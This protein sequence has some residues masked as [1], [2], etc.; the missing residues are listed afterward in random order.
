MFFAD[1]HVSHFVTKLDSYP[2]CRGHLGLTPSPLRLRYQGLLVGAPPCSLQGPCS[3]SVHTRSWK[4]IWGDTS[5]WKVRLSNRIWINT[6]SCACFKHFS[7]TKH[8]NIFQQVTSIDY[9]IFNE[10][11]EKMSFCNV[12]ISK[13]FL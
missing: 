5:V 6:A 4:R 9:I 7:M 1:K 2:F 13:S 11:N 10:K 8:S 12:E 3:Q